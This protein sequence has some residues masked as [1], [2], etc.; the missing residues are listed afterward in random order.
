[1]KKK[2]PSSCPSCNSQLQV[3]TL[4]CSSCETTVDG[5][6][7]LPSLAI[8]SPE[9]QDFIIEFVIR[10]GSLKDMANHLKLSYPT[11][12]NMLDDI[13]IKLKSLHYEN[14]IK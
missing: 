3:K 4:H 11:V 8:L 1:M 2:I 12:R 14:N 13:I 10:S 5:H 7:S 6:F 9:D